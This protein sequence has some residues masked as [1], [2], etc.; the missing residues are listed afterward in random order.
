MYNC[1]LIHNQGPEDG[2]GGVGWQLGCPMLE[3]IYR[4]VGENRESRQG[5]IIDNFQFFFKYELCRSFR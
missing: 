3:F 5:K 4:R 1:I 2:Q